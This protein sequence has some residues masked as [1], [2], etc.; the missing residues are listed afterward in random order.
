[1]QEEAEELQRQRE[2]AEDMKRLGMFP[3]FRT[4]KQIDGVEVIDPETG[5][6]IG[7]AANGFEATSMAFQFMEMQEE[8]MQDQ[9]DE[10]ASLVEGSRLKAE[11]ATDENAAFDVQPGRKMSTDRMRSELEQDKLSENETTRE[12]ATRKLERMDV[13]IQRMEALEKNDG[14]TAPYRVRSS[15]KWKPRQSARNDP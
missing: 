7:T 12:A 13:Q 1:M 2:L 3:E 14:G 6:T 8:A 5:E 11:S 10:V 4:G 9:F 15:G